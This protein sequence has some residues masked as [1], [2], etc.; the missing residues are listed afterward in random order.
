MIGSHLVRRLL[1]EH[2]VIVVDNFSRGKKE[3]IKDLPVRVVEG[4]LTDPDLAVRETVGVDEVYHLASINAGIGYLR[5]YQTDIAI[6]NILINI[7]VLKAAMKNGVDRFLFTSSACMYPQEKQNHPLAAPL[8]ETDDHPSNP[9]STYGWAKLNMEQMMSHAMREKNLQAAIVRLFNVYGPHED[10]SVD[11]HVLPSTC[12]KAIR[13]PKEPFIIWG[14]GEQT[15]S[16][17]YVE[18]AV[19]AL[20]LAMQKGINQGPINIGQTDRIS[21]NGLAD[22]II[23]LSGKSIEILH[24]PS[25]EVGVVGR[26]PDITKARNLLM[27]EPR[28][29][30]C[31]GLLFTYSWVRDKVEGSEN[32]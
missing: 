4:D 16:F 23:K 7:N 28:I 5:T 17:L 27:W 9:D 25:K 18:D 10:W 6:T 19:D 21:I 14:D 8:K 20:I 32:E 24:D 26:A 29:R 11:S 31:D 12:R 15:R 22:R 3:Y 13:Y 30:M 1:P 2:E